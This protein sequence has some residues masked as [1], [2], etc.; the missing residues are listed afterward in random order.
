MSMMSVNDTYTSTR[1]FSIVT[2][3]HEIKVAG[4][5]IDPSD[6]SR[7]HR[8]W[9]F[10]LWQLTLEPLEPFGKPLAVPVGAR[11]K[12]NVEPAKLCRQAPVIESRQ[13]YCVL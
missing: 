12:A 13:H 2:H 9:W 11:L 10:E 3:R 6:L 5:A 7:L 8:I 1:S 4:L